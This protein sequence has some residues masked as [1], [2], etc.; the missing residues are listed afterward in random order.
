MLF[1]LLSLTVY[2]VGYLLSLTLVCIFLT[3]SEHGD[4]R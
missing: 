4:K 2:A 3:S 1:I